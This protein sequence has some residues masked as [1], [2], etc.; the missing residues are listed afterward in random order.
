MDEPCTQ[1]MTKPRFI[2]N[3]LAIVLLVGLGG[4]A[5][6]VAG[7]YMATKTDYWKRDGK[8]SAE[9]M[10]RLA[11]ANFPSSIFRVVEVGRSTRFNGDGKELTICC[12]PLADVLKMKA[13]LGRDKKWAAGLPENIWWRWEIEDNA[14]RDL[15]IDRAARP[16]NYI[17][18]PNSPGNLHCILIDLIRG[19]S[20]EINIRT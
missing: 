7:F 8:P 3:L 1:T 6:L 16:E 19:I 20:Y 15:V 14:P 2:R 11:E 18:I 10:Q 5:L 9:V 13:C 4:M 17:H 12:F